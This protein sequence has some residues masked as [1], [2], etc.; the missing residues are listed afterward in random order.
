MSLIGPRPYLP[1]E[2]CRIGVNLSTILSARPGLTG[3][4]QVNGRNHVSID[5]RVQVEAWYVRNWTVWLDCIVLAKTFKAVVF[6][7][8]GVGP[9]EAPELGAA[10]LPTRAANSLESS[11][12]EL[13]HQS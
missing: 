6:P 3:F 13:F 10:A 5:E 7:E 4:W 2:R 12:I 11:R 8:N 9:A 1:R